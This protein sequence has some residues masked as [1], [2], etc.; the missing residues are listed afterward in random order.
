MFSF[1]NARNVLTNNNA[2]LVFANP[3]DQTYGG[4]ISG[5]GGLT[6]RSAGI[7]TLTAANSYLGN[8]T[9]SGGTILLGID[10]ALPAT[11]VFA[12]VAGTLDLAAST[13]W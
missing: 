12:G 9:I 4:T 3:L 13:S 11:S 10:N 2:S 1:Q 6:K 7:L 5:A 8:T